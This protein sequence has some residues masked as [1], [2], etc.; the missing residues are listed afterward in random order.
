[1]ERVEIIL[2]DITQI[3][4]DA[5]VNA[6]NP[7]LMPGGGVSG[8]IHR[9]AGPSLAEACKKVAPCPP[10][11]A[12]ITPGFNLPAKY[13]IHTVGPTWNGGQSGEARIL[14]AAYRNSLLLARQNQIR[15]IAFPSISTGIYGYPLHE[16]APIALRV[17]KE[18]AHNF[19][20]IYMVAY[21][22]LTYQAYTEAWKSLSEG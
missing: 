17:F 21:D 3:K 9:A 13:V 7:E 10:G 11:E 20:K 15:T 1:M 19:E 6:A 12:R 5:I 14:E 22:K 18:E 4:V 8:A 2:G 16:A